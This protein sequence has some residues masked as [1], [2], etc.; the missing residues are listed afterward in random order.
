MIVTLSE[1]NLNKPSY[2]RASFSSPPVEALASGELRRS[3][4][5]LR[6]W[7]GGRAGTGLGGDVV[8]EE[9]EQCG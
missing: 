2:A 4:C 1:V 3:R 9:E 6:R 7:L 5:T 8:E